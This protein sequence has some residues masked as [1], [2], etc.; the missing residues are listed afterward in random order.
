MTIRRVISAAVLGAALLGGIS[1]TIAQ[2]TTDRNTTIDRRD[3]RG[4]DLGWLGLIGLV[5]L[6]GLR[7]RNDTTRTTAR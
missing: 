3:D 1:G 6:L 7:R 5:G 2:T 4:F